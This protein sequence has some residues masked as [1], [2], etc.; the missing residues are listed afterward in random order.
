MF[1]GELFDRLHRGSP[2]VELHRHDGLGPAIHCR[3][4]RFEIDEMIGPAFGEARRRSNKVNRCCA[5]DIGMRRDDDFV[6]RTNANGMQPQNQGIGPIGNAVRILYAEE[7]FEL[8][9]EF[10]E[11]PLQDKRAALHDIADSRHDL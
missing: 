3:P 10:L 6:S 4:S 5:R 7:V 11:I 1:A 2:A 9:L 8:G